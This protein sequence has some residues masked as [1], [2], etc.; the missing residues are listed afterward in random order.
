MK[1]F[2]QVKRK[3]LRLESLH[4]GTLGKALTESRSLMIERN[5]YGSRS[6]VTFTPKTIL[7]KAAHNK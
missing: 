3:G 5:Q 4:G 1:Q 2:I 6:T 7:R